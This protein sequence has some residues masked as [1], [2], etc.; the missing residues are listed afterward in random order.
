MYCIY[1]F[2]Y[3]RSWFVH[4]LW[5]SA[6]KLCSVFGYN[7]KYILKVL[8]GHFTTLTYCL[9]LWN[10]F[11]VIQLN[12]K[13]WPLLKTLYLTK[14]RAKIW[15]LT[16]RNRACNLIQTDEIQCKLSWWYNDKILAKIKCTYKSHHHLF[17]N[18]FTWKV[19]NK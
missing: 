14:S 16:K 18:S 19:Y 17:N 8:F 15:A 2:T 1:M 7:V 6:P 5:F 11:N 9:C 4:S 12:D 3:L 13:R 10:Y